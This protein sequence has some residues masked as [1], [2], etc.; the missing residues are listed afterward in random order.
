MLR[1]SSLQFPLRQEPKYAPRSTTHFT[2]SSTAESPES[3]FT[4]ILTYSKKFP[5]W[6]QIHILE[7]ESRKDLNPGSPGQHQDLSQTDHQ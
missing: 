3:H 2:I 1:R 5:Q 4:I 6:L 7:K